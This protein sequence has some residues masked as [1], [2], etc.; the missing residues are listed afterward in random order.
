VI[1]G[2]VESGPCPDPVG[3]DG[4]IECCDRPCDTHCTGLDVIVTGSVVDVFVDNIVAFPADTLEWLDSDGDG[5]GDN[6]DAFP[7]DPN[8]TTDS[9]GDGVGD[10]TDFY[11]NDATKWEEETGIVLFVLAAAAVALLGLV[12]YTRNRH[13]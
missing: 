3:G 11:P 2:E 9:D 7:M 13:A 6:G 4:R 10:N 5:I 1:T 12:V 8:E